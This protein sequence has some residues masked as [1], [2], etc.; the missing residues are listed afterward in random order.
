MPLKSETAD[1]QAALKEIQGVIEDVV[2]DVSLN[3]SREL[4]LRKLQ[5]STTFTASKLGGSVDI[6]KAD[7]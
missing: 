3:A 7:A 2:I 4:Y 1:V 6:G 5:R